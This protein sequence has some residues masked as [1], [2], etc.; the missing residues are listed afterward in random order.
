[1]TVFKDIANFKK[2]VNTCMCV[3]GGGGGGFKFLK[4]ISFSEFKDITA[5]DKEQ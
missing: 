3:C 5:K 2:K 4:S 1:M